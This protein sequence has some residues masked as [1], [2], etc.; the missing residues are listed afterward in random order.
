[1]SATRC[2]HGVFKQCSDTP[3]AVFTSKRFTIEV[4][5]VLPVAVLERR[6]LSSRSTKLSKW[7]I[8]PQKRKIFMVASRGAYQPGRCVK[9]LPHKESQQHSTAQ[10]R[11][12][13]VSGC[14]GPHRTKL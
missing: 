3:E 10:H 9:I 13:R 14:R 8:S 7:H 1:M 6:S 12:L 2:L 11:G 5:A 4:V